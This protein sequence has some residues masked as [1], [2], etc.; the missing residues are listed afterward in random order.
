MNYRAWVGFTI[1]ELVAIVSVIGILASITIVGYN[2]WKHR[3]SDLTVKSDVVKAADGLKLYKSSRNDYPPNLA[4]TGFA[5]SE[6]VA[7]TL[8]TN[9]PQI[10]VYDTL[11]PDQNA[12]LLLNACN[13][14]MPITS[15]DEQTTYNTSC[16]FSGQNFHI[17]GQVSSN[18]VL[19]GPSITGAQFTLTC[20]PTCDSAI[21]SI[22]NQ[23]IAQGGTF[24]VEIPKKQVAL[25][26]LS[27]NTSYGSATK[28]CLEGKSTLFTDIV[29]HVSSGTVGAQPTTCAVDPELHY[30]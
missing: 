10:R 6:N 21:N 23:F 3:T 28:F 11:D 12:Q 8:Y 20:G 29:Y 19:S 22:K 9:A 5:A 24:P 7:L 16:M 14:S 17:K 27:T 18:I 15:P 25:P 30:P 4:G 26:E 1:V 13:A 2:G